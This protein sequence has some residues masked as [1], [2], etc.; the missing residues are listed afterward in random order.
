[1]SHIVTL[2]GFPAAPQP[3][4]A[5]GPSRP[6][7][8][9]GCDLLPELP[10]GIPIPPLASIA[11]HSH[12]TYIGLTLTFRLRHGLHNFN[13]ALRVLGKYITQKEGAD[14][15]PTRV[16]L[17]LDIKNMFTSI[18]L[19]N[20]VILNRGLWMSHLILTVIYSCLT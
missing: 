5:R 18:N 10:P 6:N 8:W 4:G 9:G 7:I 12:V 15:I 17:S 13:C 19:L 14:L 2:P 16:L 3:G 1:M 20:M 11:S